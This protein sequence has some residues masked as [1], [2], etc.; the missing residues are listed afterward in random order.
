MSSFRE[1]TMTTSISEVHLASITSKSATRAAGRQARRA[2]E[3]ALAQA[4]MVRVDLAELRVTP[5]FADECFGLL[6]RELGRQGFKERVKL[7][8][9]SSTCRP[10]IKHVVLH[11]TQAESAAVVS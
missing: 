7:V 8:N 1:L 3:S 2:I 11:R 4:R 9:V 10:L 5:S 6:A